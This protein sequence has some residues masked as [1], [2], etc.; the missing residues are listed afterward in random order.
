MEHEM[1]MQKQLAALP[2]YAGK[3][4]NDLARSMSICKTVATKAGPAY[5]RYAIDRA[6]VSL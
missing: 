4:K 3:C 5:I 1:L 2:R 6:Y